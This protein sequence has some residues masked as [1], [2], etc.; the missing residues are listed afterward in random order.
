MT[1]KRCKTA[2]F[3]VFESHLWYI[4][5]AA[6]GMTANINLERV[7]ITQKKAIW[8]LA[9]LGCRETFYELKILTV[10]HLY[11]REVILHAVTTSKSRFG[12]ACEHKTRNASHFLL[13]PHHFTH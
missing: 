4:C 6:C 10:T 11:T 12:D 2:Y 1:C 8:C 9:G 13:P 5:I 3:A 7:L